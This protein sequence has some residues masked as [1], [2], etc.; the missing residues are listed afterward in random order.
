MHSDVILERL[1]RLHPKAIDLSLGRIERLLEK[2]GHPERAVPPVIHIAGTNGKGSVAAYMRAALEAQG[3]RVHVYTSPH[4]VRF[5]ERIRLAGAS[6]DGSSGGGA[7]QSSAPSAYVAEDDLAAALAECERVNGGEP[8]TFFEIT[9]AAAFLLFARVPADYLILE[10]G[11]GGRLDATNVIARPAVSVVTSISIDHTQFLGDTLEAIAREK[12]GIL[13]QDVVC[14]VARQEGAVLAEIEAVAAR[15]GAPL[16]V[17]GED[18]MAFEQHGRLVYQDADGL[19]DLPLP[20]L[21]G[22]HQIDNA[23]LA[24]AA[25]RLLPDERIAVRALEAGLSTADWPGRLQRLGPG[26]WRQHVAEEVEIWL[27]GGHNAAAGRALAQA[28]G[29]LEER[30]SRP[31]VLVAGMLNSKDP[32]GF[33]KPFEGLA[34]AVWTVA[35]DGEPNALSAAE[36]AEAAGASGLGAKPAASLAEALAKAGGVEPPPRILICGSLYLAGRVLAGRGL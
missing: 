28:M 14:A 23:G 11:L 21:P 26:P 16:A 17:S 24:I 10:V 13:K 30:V 9:T 29:E 15:V 19:L 3:R 25:L 31:L 34:H 12:A 27:D 5:H 8:I 36:L 35:I 22:R 18:W 7:H 32:S 20:R 1:L 33:F 2:L 4:L 6:P